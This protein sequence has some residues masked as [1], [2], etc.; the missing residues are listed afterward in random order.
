MQCCAILMQ[1]ITQRSAKESDLFKL[2]FETKVTYSWDSCESFQKVKIRSSSVWSYFKIFKKIFEPHHQYW[3]CR[4][5]E[6]LSSTFTP[7][8]FHTA[9]WTFPFRSFIYFFCWA[10]A[11][12]KLLFCGI[13]I[14]RKCA[15]GGSNSSHQNRPYLYPRLITSPVLAL[16]IS[17]LVFVNLA[18]KPSL[19][20]GQPLSTSSSNFHS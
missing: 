4:I 18:V 12:L 20:P 9:T 3:C 2:W 14:Y 17:A 13:L 6:Q 19:P 11:S 15:C 8:S 1:T 10:V 5:L 7:I 16:I